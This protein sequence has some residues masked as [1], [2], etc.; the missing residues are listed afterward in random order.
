MKGRGCSLFFLVKVTFL[1]ALPFPLWAGE[2]TLSTSFK[3]P[4]LWSTLEKWSK[5]KA[6]AF[7]MH[8]EETFTRLGE[9]YQIYL[10]ENYPETLTGMAIMTS[11]T[12][13]VSEEVKNRWKEFALW[14]VVDRNR[15]TAREGV[16][17]PE[18]QERVEENCEDRKA[19][20]F[21]RGFAFLCRKEGKL[22]L[23]MRVVDFEKKPAWNILSAELTSVEEGIVAQLEF[24]S[25]IY[26]IMT[27]KVPTTLADLTWAIGEL[28]PEQKVITEKMLR[29]IAHHFFRQIRGVKL[30]R[31]Q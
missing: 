11:L 14:K 5:K 8:M 13:I 22:L 28:N 23:Y 27:E 9:K 2:E 25:R 12:Q 19:E 24:A 21:P 29:R 4:V 26:A 18:V 6:E 1:F 3:E 31:V 15:Q 10:L 20:E 16:I 7:G 30:V 17:S